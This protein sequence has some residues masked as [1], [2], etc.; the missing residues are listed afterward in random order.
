MMNFD[1]FANCVMEKFE[2]EPKKD[3]PY[4]LLVQQIIKKSAFITLEILKLYHE[5]FLK[6]HD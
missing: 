2:S 4:E 1:D 6:K 3:D 5:E